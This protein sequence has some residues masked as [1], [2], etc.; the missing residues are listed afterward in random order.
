MN[1]VLQE[2]GIGCLPGSTEP[3]TKDHVKL[4]STAKDDSSEIHRMGCSPYA[5]QDVKILEA[6]DH[7]LPQK[8]KDP[9][10]FTLPCFIHN[11][12][13]DK[14][15]FDLGASDKGDLEGKNQAGTLIGIPIF[16]G[17]FSII[18]GFSITDDVDITCNVVLGMPFCKK[19]VSCQKIM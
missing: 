5:V 18:S 12:C 1:K 6:Y 19:F 11:A 14:A 4:I 16:V 7:T 15:L 3:N 2:R 10:S 17:N 13:F 8:E 9:G